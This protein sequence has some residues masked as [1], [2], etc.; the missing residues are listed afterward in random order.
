M[1]AIARLKPKSGKEI[2]FLILVAFLST[3]VIS[4]AFVYLVPDLFLTVGRV[5][6]HHFAYGIL[7]LAVL[8]YL[9]LTGERSWKT[10]LRLSIVYGIALGMAFDEFVMWT[11]LEAA[12][13][14]R[15]N[16]DAVAIVTLTLLNIVYF[17]GFWRKWGHRLGKFF[18]L[19]SA[20]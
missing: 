13:W 4:R 10:R 1:R 7:L 18:H 16:I 19:V 8:C 12:Y 5:H 15:A 9:L 6:V 2:P 17:D 14:D 3:F 11:E 20:D